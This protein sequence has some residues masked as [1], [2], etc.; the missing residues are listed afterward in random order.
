MKPLRP[1]FSYFGSK[2]LLG[3]YYPTPKYDTVVEVFAGSAA[4]SLHHHTKKVILCEAYEPVA[5]VWEYLLR[6]TPERV[7]ALPDLDGKTVD[8]YDLSPPEKW[9]IGYWC[10]CA[11]ARP[12][13]SMSAWA[14]S[15]TSQLV[16]GSRVRERIASQ[17]PA[18][19]HWTVLRGRAEDVCPDIQATYF[20]D[21]PY[22][23]AGHAYGVNDV[24]YSGLAQYSRALHDSGAQVIVCEAAGADWLPF[25]PF[26]E[27]RAMTKGG[28]RTS[29]EVVW[30]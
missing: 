4:Y 14:R 2:W 23:V 6:V 8:D 16:W 29:K 15:A 20:I 17:L 22:Q 19:R 30:P 12:R 25:R 28:F 5:A 1:F 24:D 13:K 18:I 3:K 11:V 27:V 10:N 7:R 9:L 21:P 26:R